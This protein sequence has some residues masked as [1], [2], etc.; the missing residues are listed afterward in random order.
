MAFN[1]FCMAALLARHKAEYGTPTGARSHRPTLKPSDTQC[2]ILRPRR[3]RSTL[4]LASEMFTAPR[5]SSA[6]ARYVDRRGSTLA[7]WRSRPNTS[8]K[9]WSMVRGTGAILPRSA[10]T[11]TGDMDDSRKCRRGN[12]TRF[13]VISLMSTFSAPSK[14]IPAVKFSSRFAAM[15][16][17][18]SQG[19]PP[20]PARPRTSPP[21]TPLR[22]L[23]RFTALSSRLAAGAPPDAP[24][25]VP[26]PDLVSMDVTMSI[27][28]W[29]STGMTQSACSA[30]AAHDSMALYGDVM[31]SS[32]CEGNTDTEKR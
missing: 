21:S 14:R 6:H 28:A 32:S 3:S 11:T 27:S 30:S 16:F 12:G 26:V 5:S 2:A 13:M 25:P 9:I 15:P 20:C 17:M 24:G 22:E 7:S 18:P 4:R 29:F 10:G 31:T 8:V 19:V 1:G 23:P